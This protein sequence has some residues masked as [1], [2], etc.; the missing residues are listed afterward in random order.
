MDISIFLSADRSRLT[1]KN[2]SKSMTFKEGSTCPP[3]KLYDILHQSLPSRTCVLADGRLHLQIPTQYEV[4]IHA[5]VDKALALSSREAKAPSRVESIAESPDI[6]STFAFLKSRELFRRGK[7]RELESLAVKMDAVDMS[8]T[9]LVIF[10]RHLKKGDIHHPLLQETDWIIKAFKAY[11]A[12]YLTDSE[13][14]AA[15]HLDLFMHLYPDRLEDI[16]SLDDPVVKETFLETIDIRATDV[17]LEGLSPLEKIILPVEIAKE[18]NDFAS[19]TS[20]LIHLG[21]WKYF[22]YDSDPPV[23]YIPSPAAIQRVLN[24]LSPAYAVEVFPTF[25]YSMK[26]NDFLGIPDRRTLGAH[27]RYITQPDWLHDT[28][29]STPF[30]MYFHDYAVHSLLTSF[31]VHR[32]EAD[33][34][35]QFLW[36]KDKMHFKSL[37]EFFADRPFT[38]Y[39][40]PDSRLSFIDIEN[41]HEFFWLSILFAISAEDRKPDNNA[42][43]FIDVFCEWYHTQTLTDGLHLEHLQTLLK[44]SADINPAFSN[45]CRILLESLQEA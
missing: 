43:I 8:E 5:I 30:D 36:A 27:C 24:A 17:H 35:A 23:I 29:S 16:G 21:K 11:Q 10:A 7:K 18:K 19:F 22:T 3:A 41:I 14:T 33:S 44:K 9:D 12:G 38:Y 20:R 39:Y 28:S 26:M 13:L 37:V 34:L 45:A 6:A 42:A 32:K 25:G 31:D 15:S 2:N 1:I 40:H 4:D